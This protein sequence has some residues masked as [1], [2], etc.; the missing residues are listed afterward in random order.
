[1][2]ASFWHARTPAKRSP[3]RTCVSNSSP[4]GAHEEPKEFAES[5]MVTQTPRVSDCCQEQD[6]RI[7]DDTMV[8]SYM[9]NFMAAIVSF[10][11]RWRL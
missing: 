7:K 9:R 3:S 4:S 1:M 11:L 5:R 6:I 8:L 2:I 10:I